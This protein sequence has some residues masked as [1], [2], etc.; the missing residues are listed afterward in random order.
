[1]S[2]RRHWS[3]EG[4][5]QGVWFRESTRQAAER[6]GGVSGWVKNTRDGRVE[7]LADASD[8]GLDA[9]SVFL[10]EGSSL[11]RVERVTET[12]M[13][14]GDAPLSGFRIRG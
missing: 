8:D 4:H 5:V 2:P 3:V 9:L 6:I 14:E 7:V 1:M 13:P 11:S 10:A 12:E